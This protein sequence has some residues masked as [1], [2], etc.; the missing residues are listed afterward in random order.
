MLPVFPF[1]AVQ[2]IFPG[3][4][5]TDSIEACDLCGFTL[6][7]GRCDFDYD[8]QRYHF[9]CLGCR[10]VFT[11]LAEAE[12]GVDAE[13]FRRSEIFRRCRELGVIPSSEAELARSAGAVAPTT[14]VAVKPPPG[15]TGENELSLNLRVSGMWCP[16]CA[17][18]IEEALNKAPG[19]LGAACSFAADRVRIRY[20]PRRTAPASLVETIRSLGYRPAD[21]RT[22]AAAEARRQLWRL[23]VTVF[24]TLNVM[25][26]QFSLY[27]GF[28]THLPPEAVAYLSWP[29]FLLSLTVLGYGG[30]DILRKAW[31]GLAGASPGMETLVAVGALSAFGYSTVNLLAGSIHLYFD[32][33]AMLVTLVLLGKTL[34]SRAR[35]RVRATLESFFSLQP[36]KVRLKVP[37]F[38]L[39][40]YV[41]A[42]H[43]K[44]GDVLLAG[45]GEM[46]AADG[47][48]L[49][50]RSR[51]DES[52]LT[53]EARP[54]AK[55]PGD[56]IYSGARV[57]GETLEI[58]A[59]AG[60]AGSLLGQMIAL[61]ETALARKTHLEDRT[62][63]WL[64]IL[65]PLVIVMAAVTGLV[66]RG[67]GVPTEE[68]LV[69]AVTVLV[70]T[71]PC[72]LG[73]AIPL[74]RVAGIGLAGRHGILVRDG[75]VFDRIG[76]VDTLIFDKTGTVTEG[77]WD[78]LAME[79]F[80]PWTPD[81]ALAVAAGLEA[82]SDHPAADAIRRLA[83]EKGTP[84]TAMEAV[85]DAV[86]GRAGRWDGR[87][88]RIGSRA[89]ALPL[90]GD[91]DSGKPSSAG[92]VEGVAS[93]VWL[94]ADGRPASRFVLGDRL[95]PEMA[96]TMADLRRRGLHLELVSGD[97]PAAAQ[98][99]ADA[100]GM[101]AV[102]GGMRPEA[103]ARHVAD[104]E[105]AGRRVAMVGDGINDAPAL[106]AAHVAVAVFG[107]HPLGREAADLTLMGAD[108][109]RLPFFLDLSARIR[110]KVTQNLA[111]ALVYNLIAIPVAM[112]GLLSPLV[113]VA[114][115]LLSSLSVIGNTLRLLRTPVSDRGA[116]SRPGHQ[117]IGQESRRHGEHDHPG[118]QVALATPAL[119]KPARTEAQGQEARQG[120]RPEGGHH[121]HAGAR[122]PGGQGARQGG[123]GE[124]AGKQS[125]QQADPQQ[126]AIAAPGERSAQQ[127]GGPGNLGRG[128][129]G[130][131]L[132]L[133][134]QPQP[135]EAEEQK[136]HGRRRREGHL[137]AD[138]PDQGVGAHGGG[139]AA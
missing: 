65:V 100:L 137:A 102:S 80:D 79:A 52:S 86:E 30:R 94:S 129:R 76:D 24:L 42:D 6:R 96:A 82:G 19:V 115:M 4:F 49:A 88:W 55:G 43:I 3:F 130:Q 16:A 1:S 78:V 121:R 139:P 29:S 128:G 87:C 21:G 45:G 62:D 57:A 91:A 66:A 108:P 134:D 13:A 51:V 64:R 72:A 95:R 5:M 92:S 61:L 53:G 68:A 112:A 75:A 119:K 9:C 67:F 125:Q 34:E 71:C 133:A 98:Q 58:R 48:V 74:A 113:A 77:C 81:A 120:A 27:S 15:P 99:V 37:G 56:R 35:D 25:M 59:E 132:R 10:Q 97:A 136:K 123:I 20:D 118:D 90:A 38:A 60:V 23:L 63:R 93:V 131:P 54:V 104:L 40:R 106:S 50:G 46:V 107:G 41:P 73:I 105:A 138:D 11:M 114:A 111:W 32:T 84:A 31:H 28:F 2:P 109:R 127:T 18:V 7:Y 44:P 89:F 110:R 14:V 22:E 12:G 124:P 33:A 17:W 83:V 126:V 47:V 26:L 135:A 39:G 117:G 70:I 103:K 122:A 8:G 116:P 69:R 101:E 85:D 36:T